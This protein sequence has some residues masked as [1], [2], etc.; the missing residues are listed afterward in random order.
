MEKAIK[1]NLGAGKD[2]REGYINVDNQ[3]MY[4]DAKVDFN[5]DIKDFSISNNST[6]EILL[7]HVTMY[8]RPEELR[9]LLKKWHKWLQVGGKMII[10]TADFRKL[11]RLV[12][13]TY[14]KEIVISHGL[15]N[16]FGTKET[17]PHRWG[18]TRQTLA[19]ELNIAGFSKIKFERGTKKPKRDFIIIGIK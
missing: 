8:L 14:P 1:I 12:V 17:G 6:E 18:W 5:Q 3:Q 10:E 7:S 9:P 13:S 4:P 16:I 2:Y 11:C 19:D 15:I